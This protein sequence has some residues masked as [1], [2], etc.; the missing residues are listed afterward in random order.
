[1]LASQRGRLLDAMAGA[2]AEHGY[3]GAT[4]AHVVSGAGVSRKTAHEAVRQ[5]CRNRRH[6]LG[7]YARSIGLNPEELGSPWAAA[8]S[9]LV[10]FAAGA[11]VPLVPWF[12]RSG[13]TAQVASLGLAAVASC[14]IGALLARLSGRPLLWPAMRQLLIVVLAAGEAAEGACP[15]AVLPERWWALA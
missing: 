6:V 3:G 9:S 14:S 7:T 4:V 1:M 2:V 13:L 8:L 5:L 11:L 15:P 10:T 12:F